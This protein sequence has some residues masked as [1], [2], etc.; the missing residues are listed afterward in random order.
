M[1][2]VRAYVPVLYAEACGNV[3]KVT[4]ACEVYAHVNESSIVIL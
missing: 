1:L 2:D 4:T 3:G